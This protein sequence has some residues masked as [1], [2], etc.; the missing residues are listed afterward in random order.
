[1]KSSSR[2]S[3]ETTHNPQPR[4]S[5]VQH[6]H[7]QSRSTSRRWS[8]EA[9]GW[10]EPTESPRTGRSTSAHPRSPRATEVA[11][12]LNFLYQQSIEKG[13]D[14]PC[15]Q[16]RRPS[17]CSKYRPVSLTSIAC[18]LLEHIFC[19][20]V[21]RHLD[22]HKILCENNHGFR[23]KHSMETQLLLT[24]HK[25]LKLRDTG[26]QL[27]VVI[28]DF[29]KAFDKVPH[30]WLQGKLDFYGIHGN[31]LTWAEA[32]LVGRTQ[33][34]LLDGI[35]CKEKDV[36][37]TVPQGTV[38]GPLMFLLCINDLPAH[39][40][41]CSSC[42]L[43]ADDCLLYRP[44]ESIEDQVQLQRDLC[45]LEQWASERGMV[46]SP[47]KCYV[48]TVNRGQTNRPYLYEL[49]RTILQLWWDTRNA[50]QSQWHY[51]CQGA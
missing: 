46:F 7:L 13:M 9:L 2:Y 47:L 34:V 17:R 37:S 5:L 33:S 14:Y 40:G 32:F 48:M 11:P 31:L 24:T 30:Q 27:D 25:M 12:A 23:A 41:Q 45:N 4:G 36:H 28:L 8:A 18:K 38:L 26:K 6:T 35:R 16:E 1:M 39:M 43:F 49:C 19:W 29:S 15:L 22:N 51:K 50:P 42:R 21:R 10:P 3:P 20:H 44:V